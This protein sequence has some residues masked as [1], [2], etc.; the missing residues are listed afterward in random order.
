M[1]ILLTAPPIGRIVNVEIE[2]QVHVELIVRLFSRCKSQQK[3]FSPVYDCYKL[4][5]LARRSRSTGA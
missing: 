2:K 1:F 4:Y 3:T 5:S